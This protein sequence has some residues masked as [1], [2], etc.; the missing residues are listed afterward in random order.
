LNSNTKFGTV[1]SFGT[2]P[3]RRLLTNSD[4]NRAGLCHEG[5]AIDIIA[6]RGVLGEQDGRSE[7][8]LGRV[9]EEMKLSYEV[10][11]EQW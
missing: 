9:E 3:K 6:G 11:I 1:E 2:F 5:C 8:R 7:M 4:E 10:T